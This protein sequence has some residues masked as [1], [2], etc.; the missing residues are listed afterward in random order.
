VQEI[1]QSSATISSP[2]H[3]PGAGATANYVWFLYRIDVPYA[4]SLG[5]SARLSSGQA[6]LLD[7][8]AH[9]AI[10]T[11]LLKIGHT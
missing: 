6:L 10:L 2:E 4:S 3:S 8:A 11:A 5:R 1:L 9:R 7:P